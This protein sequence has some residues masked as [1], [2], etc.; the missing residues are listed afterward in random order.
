MKHLLTLILT[1]GMTLAVFSQTPITTSVSMNPTNYQVRGSSTNFHVSNADRGVATVATLTNL[2]AITT[3]KHGAIVDVRG[4]NA[5]GDLPEPLRYVLNTNS[6]VS[7][8]IIAIANAGGAGRWEHPWDGN[9]HAFGVLPNDLTR[10]ASNGVY[11]AAASTHSRSTGKPLKFGPGSYYYPGDLDVTDVTLIS[12]AGKIGNQYETILYITSPNASA[13]T[14]L[15][16][17]ATIENL[18]IRTLYYSYAKQSTVGYGVHGASGSSAQRLSNLYIEGFPIGVGLST[19]DSLIENVDVIAAKPFV[20]GGG[21]TQNTFLRCAA[22]GNIVIAGLTND[23]SITCASYTAGSTNFTV[24]D[25]TTI[26]VGDYIR[27]RDSSEYSNTIAYRFFPRKVTAKSGNDITINYPW[28][29]GFTNG[30]FEFALGGSGTSAFEGNTEATYVGCNAEYGS[31]Q[32]IISNNSGPTASMAVAGVL[33]IE[34]WVADAGASSDNFV[35]N[36]I[37]TSFSG[38]AVDMANCVF[39]DTQG[40]ALFEGGTR[41]YLDTLHVRDFEQYQATPAFWVFRTLTQTY[42]DPAVVRQLNNAG[43]T[44]NQYTVDGNQWRNMVNDVRAGDNGDQVKVEG[45]GIGRATFFGLGATP[46]SGNYVRGDKI[47]TTAGEELLC[48]DTGSFR[49]AAGSNEMRNGSAILI[50]DQD[51]R[52]VLGRRTP[53]AF[54][55]TNGA[56]VSTNHMIVEALLRNSP[57]TTT[58]AASVASNAF[59]VPLVSASGVQQGDP[60]I[61]TEGTKFSDGM[62]AR[63]Q[64]NYVW[65]ASR[66]TN[67]FTTS[68]TFRTGLRMFSAS[69]NDVHPQPVKFA[70]PTFLTE[71]DYLNQRRVGGSNVTAALTVEGG[72]NG[73]A[74]MVLQRTGVGTNEFLFSGDQFRIRDKSDSRYLL[75]SLKSGGTLYFGFGNSSANATPLAVLA[76]AEAGTGTNVSGGTL[77]LRSGQGTGSSSGA[78]LSLA[79]P[80]PG[81]SGATAQSYGTGLRIQF[82]ATP[83]A[84]VSNSPIQ[85]LRWD[86]TN[87]VTMYQTWTN[88]GGLWRQYWR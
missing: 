33:H 7:T 64:G 1:A 34:G 28:E 69:T 23:T 32:Y 81:A 38:Q 18:H 17:G 3:A 86:G 68:A 29:L 15:S 87:W 62:V 19:F 58:L 49:T 46:S 83:D 77:T 55:V 76:Q 63:V 30:R 80:I 36:G 9:V 61:L 74:G 47:I 43:A 59:M 40:P 85:S 41:G 57:D 75:S 71:R 27:V 56:T 21:G 53:V 50:V 20:V 72:W 8:N 14:N 13:F 54:A 84:S 73:S 2:A 65:S 66:I 4:I 79:A 35:F 11:L 12:G 48:L 60:F 42:G 70:P 37:N 26:A 44:V 45:F 5:D 82:P 52:A 24:S 31:W 6:I 16:T 39:Y 25:G 10:S 67:A 22:R 88:E 78:A 51:A